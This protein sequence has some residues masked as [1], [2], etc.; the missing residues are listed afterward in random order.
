MTGSTA[1]LDAGTS[2]GCCC[3][4][5][6]DADSDAVVDAGDEVC[7]REFISANLLKRLRLPTDV[8]T[9]TVGLI[10]EMCSL[11]QLCSIFTKKKNESNVSADITELPLFF[12]FVGGVVGGDLGAWY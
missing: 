4:C 12:F 8:S 11:M 9:I 10:S 7:S 3:C 1:E 2:A 6:D 5:Q